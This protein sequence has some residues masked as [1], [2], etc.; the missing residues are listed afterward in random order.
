MLKL[1]KIG[2]VCK[3]L[4]VSRGHVYVLMRDHGLPR[5]VALSARSRAWRLDQLE[6]WVESRSA[7]RDELQ[8]A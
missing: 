6:Q 2:E 1:L 8:A 5:P 7:T 4:G 3:L